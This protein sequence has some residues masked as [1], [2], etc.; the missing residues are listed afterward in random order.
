MTPH[1]APGHIGL[2]VTDLDRSTSFYQHLLGFELLGRS[3]EVGRRFSFLGDGT[4][5]RLTLWQQAERVF[6]EQRAGLHHLAF[7]VSS[8]DELGHFEDRLR[9]L[10]VTPLHGGAVAHSEGSASGGLFFLD[11]DGIRLEISTAAGLENAPAPSGSAPS[12][13][14]F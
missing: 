12:C 7:E 6:D 5:L 4:R 1:P 3:E 9:E 8:A 2:N 13:G 10:G 14:F 11:P